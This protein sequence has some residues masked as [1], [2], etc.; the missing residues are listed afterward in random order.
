MR[1]RATAIAHPNIA[2]VKYWGKRHIDLNLPAAGSLSVT[3]A[4]LETR[5]T[6]EFDPQ[7]D[8]DI[9]FINDR[10]QGGK[11]LNRLVHFID[12]LRAMADVTDRAHIRSHNN[13]PTAAG[14]ASSASGFAALA[15]AGCAALGLEPT[16]DQLSV[17]ARLGSGSAARSV[18]GGYVE[19]MPGE[20]EDGTDSFAEPFAGPSHWDLRCLVVLTTHGEKSIGST[21]AMTH[22]ADTSPYYDAWIDSVPAAIDTAR[23]AILE[24][25]FETLA[26]VSEHSCLKFHASAIA[27]NPGILY[28]NG[29]TIELMHQ[30]RR[31]RAEGMK[32]FFTI[33]AGPH[34][35]VFCEASQVAAV[36]AM[37]RAVE[38]VDKLLE[39]RPGQ[40][41]RLEEDGRLVRA[42]R[43]G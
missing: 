40:G 8:K 6:V 36:K 11:R 25:D 29:L 23:E 34:V 30:V 1:K 4:G 27:S 24:H 41:V 39:T 20:A 2:L 26:K 28:W 17:L 37:L 13:F 16:R 10:V 42:W 14:L 12:R 9:I 38:G 22:T 31:M 19:M 7:L 43:E 35:K 5:T 15:A 21:E 33:D 32:V 3:L 18:S